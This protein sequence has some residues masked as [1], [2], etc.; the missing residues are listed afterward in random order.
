MLPPIRLNIYSHAGVLRRPS[1]FPPLCCT[2]KTTT[3]F[4]PA[5]SRYI[6]LGVQYTILEQ[7]WTQ[8]RTEKR[9]NVCAP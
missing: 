5:C 4:F 8:N 7:H 9:A 1:L 2:D 3:P 6:C